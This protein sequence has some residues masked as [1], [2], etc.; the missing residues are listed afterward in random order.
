MPDLRNNLFYYATKELS[1]DAFICWLC[2]YALED[3]SERDEALRECAID[4]V[5]A[6]V[7]EKG[8]DKSKVVLKDVQK[9]IGNIDVLLTASC[10]GN[11]YKIIV[12]D[13]IFA[14]EH[15]G[16]LERY[17]SNVGKEV[18]DDA[19]VCIY[20]KTGFQSDYTKVEQAGYI[21]F[22]RR[23][24]LS[25]L[26]PYASKT[27]N[28][29]FLDYYEYWKDFETITQSYRTV[30][31]SEINDKRQVYGFFEDLQSCIRLDQ[32]KMWAE[33]GYVPN[34]SGGFHGL[35]FGMYDDVIEIDSLKAALYLQLELKWEEDH[36]GHKICLKLE[37]QS[38]KKNERFGEL[39]WKFVGALGDFGFVKPKRL[40]SGMHVTVGMYVYNQ[41]ADCNGLKSIVL[42]AI[43]QYRKL[44]DVVKKGLPVK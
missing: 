20:F 38:D 5:G 36:Y 8:L 13:K 27:D 26:E 16:Q 17:K 3:V 43:N 1:Q 2:S 23:R 19:I 33:F 29:V 41:V 22:D 7:E 14:S 44:F 21:V 6:F 12:E 15:G 30:P 4:L 10:E 40:G 34:A 18:Q 42:E 9:Q 25:I 37:N 32:K 24:L 31:L 39:K 28:R 11:E 35:W